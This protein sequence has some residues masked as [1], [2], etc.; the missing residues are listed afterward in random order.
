MWKL[1]IVFVLGIT[2]THSISP[3]NEISARTLPSPEIRQQELSYRLPTNVRPL[4]YTLSINVDVENEVF[5][6][7]VTINLEVTTSTTIIHLN[8]KEIIVGWSNA[9]LSLDATGQT[10]Q[11][12]NQVDRPIEQIYELH[13]QSDLAVGTYTLELQFEGNIR[14]DLTGLYKSSYIF[15]NETLTET[16]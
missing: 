11:V 4:T 8:Y 2:L 3:I 5:G 9:R 15:S 16:R 1:F 12:I 14:H 13:F 10:F 7:N 6:G